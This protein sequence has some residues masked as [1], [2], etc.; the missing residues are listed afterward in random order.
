[1]SRRR[2]KKKWN[3]GFIDLCRIDDKGE[4]RCNDSP[5][6]RKKFG[7]ARYLPIDKDENECVKWDLSVPLMP[8]GGMRKSACL[9]WKRTRRAKDVAGKPGPRSRK[10]GGKWGSAQGAPF[11]SSTSKVHAPT[12]GIPPASSCPAVQTPVLHWLKDAVKD[13]KL[14]KPG[15]MMN[16]LLEEI[17]RKCLACYATTGNYAYA[18]TQQAMANRF[19]WFNKTPKKQVVEKMIYAIKHAGD[20]HCV[21]GKGCK[22]TPGVQPK[23]FRAFDSGDFQ[24]Q[25]DVDIWTEVAKALPETRFWFPTTA[26]TGLCHSTPADTKKFLGALRKLNA[27]PNAVVRPS[28]RGLDVPAAKVPGLGPGSAVVE[29]ITSAKASKAYR[30]EEKI[31]KRGKKTEKIYRTRQEGRETTRICDKESGVCTTH[32]VCPGNC[33]TCRQCWEKNVPVVYRR[34]GL[35]PRAKNIQKLVRKVTGLEEHAKGK[36]IDKRPVFDAANAKIQ[37]NFGKLFN[38][39]FDGPAPPKLVWE[40]VVKRA[41]PIAPETAPRGESEED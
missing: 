18:E 24:S 16:R 36:K 2:S 10:V 23:Y 37:E 8:S 41:T 27:L 5:A 15:A 14:Q 31:S 33:A 1:M 40:Q 34:H 38:E 9:K 28:S 20:E 25:R 22:F 39:M 4:L 35:L 7:K 19:D 32:W 12:F 6:V 13:P 21:E 17:P 11:F 26:Y 3:V 30:V 29:K